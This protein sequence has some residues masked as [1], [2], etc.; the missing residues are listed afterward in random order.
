MKLN[1]IFEMLDVNTRAKLE[2]P[3]ATVIYSIR[4]HPPIFHFRS[5]ALVIKGGQGRRQGRRKPAR[6]HTDHTKPNQL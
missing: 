2:I 3:L 1:K 6:N 5:A 4:R